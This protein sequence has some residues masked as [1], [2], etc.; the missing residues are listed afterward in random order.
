MQER[1]LDSSESS[2]IHQQQLRLLEEI[3]ELSEV[4]NK[5]ADTSSKNFINK[6]FD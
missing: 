6:F 5:L 2:A 3:G 4:T 1:H